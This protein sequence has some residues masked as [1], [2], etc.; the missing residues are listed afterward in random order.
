MQYIKRH[1]LRPSAVDLHRGGEM[2]KVGLLSTFGF[3]K[4]Y[5]WEGRRQVLRP[6]SSLLHAPSA[7]DTRQQLTQVCLRTRVA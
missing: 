1:Y 7:E 4:D 6:A 2:R 5:F 3:Q